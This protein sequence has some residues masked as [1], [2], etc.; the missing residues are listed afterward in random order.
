M[1]TSI[2]KTISDEIIRKLNLALQAQTADDRNIVCTEIFN[3]ITADVEDTARTALK[4]K[5][6]STFYEVLAAFYR[7]TPDEAEKVLHLCQQ[8]WSNRYIVAVYTVLLHLWLLLGGGA[9]GSRAGKLL[10]VL[11]AGTKQVFQLDTTQGTDRFKRLHTN[12]VDSLQQLQQASPGP[13]SR[14][15]A[16]EPIQRIVAAYVPYYTPPRDVLGV[17]STWPHGAAAHSNG[18]G[19]AAEE[20]GLHD[21]IVT[22]M[23]VLM[24]DISSVKGLLRYLHGVEPVLLCAEQWKGDVSMVPL[25]RL[26]GELYSLTLP[27]GPRYCPSEVRRKA[28]KLL[29]HAFPSG[30]RSRAIVRLCFRLMHPGDWPALLWLWAAGI[31]SGCWEWL[32]WIAARIWGLWFWI[33]HLPAGRRRT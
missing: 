16:V 11:L 29:D 14:S 7:Q 18:H 22:E 21:Y 8:L 2:E 10:V 5:D 15:P 27:G 30:S 24:H 23:A 6:I 13:A 20:P 1:S 32:L 17:L 9:A 31:V 25:L 33:W 28:A 26:Q 12:M 4:T 3:D 19:A